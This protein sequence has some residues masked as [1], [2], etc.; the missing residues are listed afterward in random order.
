MAKAYPNY[1]YNNHWSYDIESYP[2]IFCMATT[3]ICSGTQYYF[4]ISDWKDDSK[5]LEEF[6]YWMKAN[7]QEQVGFNNQ[8]YDWPV[9]DFAFR[10][11][12]TGVTAGMIY[13]KSLAVL[14][15][16]QGDDY[17]GNT[18]RPWQQ[19]I[20]QHDLYR[21]NH[22]D[23]MAKATSLKMLEFNMRM[24]SIQE[25]PYQPGTVLTQQ[26][27]YN[28]GMYNLH[29]DNATAM[30]ANECSGAIGLRYE[31]GAKYGLEIRNHSE[32]SIGAAFFKKRLE[33]KGI[34]T[35]SK[36]PREYIDFKDII[37][38]YVSFERPEFQ[39]LLNFFKRTRIHGTKE[40]LNDL[41]VGY[42][43][44]QYMNRNG[45]KLVNLPQIVY[46]YY[47][48]KPPKDCGLVGKTWV[49]RITSF[50]DNFD[51]ALYSDFIVSD[52]I[53]V[54][55][56]GFQFD[57]GTGGIHGSIPSAIVRSTDDETIEDVD[58]ASYYPNL[59][60]KNKVFPLHLTE[61]FC[62]I[63]E[64]V[65]DERGLYPK[66]QFPRINKAIKLALNASYGNSNSEYSF[67]YDPQ[68]TMTI[69]INGQLL[70]CMLA[71]QILKIPG[72]S[73]IQ[74]NTD[75]ITYK[76][77]NIYLDHCSA[78]AR[79]WEQLTKLE[80]E[81]VRY[82]AMYIKDVSNYIAVSFKDDIKLK[83][84]YNYKYAEEGL[85]E[86]DFSALIVPKAAEAYLLYG[87]DIESFIRGHND[88]FDF[89]LRTKVRRSDQLLLE[90]PDGTETKL[91]RITRYYVAKHGGTLS[92]EMPPTDAQV[93]K[94]KT[95]DHYRHKV[96]GKYEVKF[97]GQK[98]SSGMYELVPVDQREQMP[99]RRK[100]K[101]ESNYIVAECNNIDNF[102][103]QNLD[104]QYYIDEARKLIDPLL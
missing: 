103:W 76:V 82:K 57:F 18:I 8:D 14:F 50:P 39:A 22:F 85:W 43:L 12:P 78:L 34:S 10:S 6:L 9:V 31:F 54:V 98:P 24:H 89:C 28:L 30:F 77:K 70:L 4:E 35:D 95:G 87:K 53:N 51:M 75:G 83:G 46:D 94:W 65:Y 101:L 11:I 97:A 84:A 1:P 104:Y 86:R 27:A 3:H 73:I 21:I 33:E 79:W 45:L 60:I 56:D 42:E 20:P 47:G 49:S 26:E 19:W 44:A 7:N 52:N 25:L 29:D 41:Y 64:E 67:F 36:T 71:E 72:A 13:E 62:P 38:N 100:S 69:T 58:V 90:N 63:Y 16:D 81:A 93:D 17:W 92:K 80:L 40:V 48:V 55:V 61:A 66:K 5:L 68:Y 23:N 32:A 74:I 59:A 37:F 15:K 2:N 96:N 91:Q 102:N 88:H 99:P